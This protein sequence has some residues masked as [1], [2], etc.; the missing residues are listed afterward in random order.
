MD[1]LA[2]YERPSW[3]SIQPSRTHLCAN[4]HVSS[5]QQGITKEPVIYTVICITN[6]ISWMLS[7]TGSH[8]LCM[9]ILAKDSGGSDG[10]LRAIAATGIILSQSSRWT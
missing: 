7:A 5:Q 8:L 3:I 9:R 4:R 6:A 2:R 1:V 10:V